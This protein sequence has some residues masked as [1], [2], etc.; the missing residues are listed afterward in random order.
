MLGPL[1]MMEDH[2]DAYFFWKE[3]GI[4][5]APCL[6]IDAH[7]DMAYLQT[8]LDFQVESPELNCA[9]YLLRAVEEGIVSEVVWVVPPHL[10]AGFE[11]LLHWTYHELPAWLPLKLDEHNSLQLE[12]GRVC[13]TLRNVPF[14][15]CTSANMPALDESWLLD[16]DVDYFL[17]EMDGVF[18]S[19]LQLYDRLAGQ[20]FAAVTV[21][22][23]VL[24]GYTPLFRRY[25]GDVCELLWQEGRE[26][27]SLYWDRLHGLDSLEHAEAQ[28]QAA[29]LATRAWGAGADHRGPAW[30]RAGAVCPKYQV[31]PFEVACYYWLRK[32]FERCRL[33]L[34]QVDEVRRLYLLGF[35]AFEQKRFQEAASR[36]GQLLDS[37]QDQNVDAI[38]RAHLLTL[39][40]RAWAQSRQPEQGLPAL[41]EAARLQPRR[42]EVWRELARCQKRA[43]QVPE[44]IKSFKRSVQLAPEE[45]ASIEAQLEL[46]ELY[47][48]EGQL[49]LAQGLHRQLQKRTLPGNLRLQAERLPVKIALQDSPLRR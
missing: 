37:L 27:G 35:I 32:K 12:E 40:G 5:S 36:W 10:F 39:V 25:L 33:W 49:L 26:A 24:G 28:L 2:R 15:I 22:Y 47:V 43:G 44:A 31:D 17:D 29:A 41:Q 34:E 20:R 13:G 16:L 38:S 4:Q 18:E 1:R 6:H 3:L 48:K 30:E 46:G 9:N 11:D 8:P 7:L 19:P 23:S 45:V 21:A 42:P 14:S